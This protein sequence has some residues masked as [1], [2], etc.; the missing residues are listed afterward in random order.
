MKNSWEYISTVLFAICGTLLCSEGDTLE[1][2]GH[3]TIN[4]FGTK[5]GVLDK[6][7]MPTNWRSTIAYEFDLKTECA[8]T[9][10]KFDRKIIRDCDRKPTEI[11][12]IFAKNDSGCVQFGL[13][14]DF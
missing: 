4:R 11:V 13:R 1:I 7:S 9:Y 14:L 8:Y 3:Q 12:T 2:V 10:S 6:N 5:A